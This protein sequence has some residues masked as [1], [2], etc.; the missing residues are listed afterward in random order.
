MAHVSHSR[1][2]VETRTA[3]VSGTLGLWWKLLDFCGL[4]WHSHVKR[5]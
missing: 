2:V 3:V 4:L 1:I 5:L